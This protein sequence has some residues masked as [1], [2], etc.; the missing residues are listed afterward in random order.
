MPVEVV[1]PNP[2]CGASYSVADEEVGR[3]AR[4]RKCGR[5]FTAEAATR[6]P[7]PAWPAEDW[8]PPPL[9]SDL[10]AGATFGRYRIVRRLGRGGM[11]AVYLAH[12]TEL[13]RPVALKVPHILPEDGPEFL[14]RFRREARAAAQLTHPHI[15][16]IY[17]VGQVGGIPYLTMDFIEGRPLSDL[18]AEHNGLMSE[19]DAARLVR[20]LALALA[21][22][23]AKGVVHRGLKPANVMIRDD[24]T[25]IVMDFG[26]ARRDV[27]ERLTVSGAVMGTPAYMPPE[28]VNGEVRSIGP[29]SDIYSL[30]AVL[31]ELLTGRLPFLGSGMRLCHLILSEDPARPS[32]FQPDLDLRLEA[33]CLKAMEKDPA[34]RFASMAELAAALGELTER[35]VPPALAELVERRQEKDPVRRPDSAVAVCQALADTEAGTVTPAASGSE[36]LRKNR[37]SGLWAA[38]PV[39]ARQLRRIGL[40]VAWGIVLLGAAA[41]LTLRPVAGVVGSLALLGAAVLL[42]SR[43]VDRPTGRANQAPNLTGRPAPRRPP[44]RTQ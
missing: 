1:C 39:P 17:D 18:I 36:T 27:D 28:Q 26:L 44:L 29:R 38:A 9:P 42:V 8:R 43:L 24:G 10:A 5:A 25:P 2:D 35:D 19:R 14:Q 6:T 30:G 20:T 33:I 21:A 11:G 23:H 22:A 13:D 40:A 12:D 32:A 4:C 15:G 16:R 37:L 31:Y 41:L 3:R 34:A 7:A